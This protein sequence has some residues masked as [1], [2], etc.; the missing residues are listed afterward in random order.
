MKLATTTGDF[1]SCTKSQTESMKYIRESGFLYADYNF[2]CDLTSMSGIFSDDKN[3]HIREVIKTSEECGIKLVQSHAPMGKPLLDADGSFVKINTDC[4]EACAELGIPNIV[5][6]AGYDYGLT[7]EENFE[8][9]KKFFTPL[10]E[11]AE[12]Y[13]ID[14]LVENFNKMYKEGVYWVDN[15]PDLLKLIEYVDHKNFHAVWDTGHANMQDM[16]QDEALRL[17]GKH[18]KAV[19]IQD[20]KGT[21]DLH[22]APFF[23]TLNMDEVMNGLLDIGFE[24]YFTFE[25]GGMFIGANKRRPYERDSRLASAPLSLRIEFE[26]YLYK[27]GK[28]VLEAYDCFEE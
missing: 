13:N 21:K 7:V 26:K 11:C 5:V 2:G 24:G 20:N 23:G 28:T 15:A 8:R 19:H 3:C 16:P 1:F 6:H 9:N 4:I 10:L 12:K 14:V 27:L 25:V 18:V 22:H 17:L